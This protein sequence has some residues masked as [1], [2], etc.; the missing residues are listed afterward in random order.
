MKGPVPS[1]LDEGSG[2]VF[3]DKVAHTTVV[4]QQ[5]EE[6]FLQSD[7]FGSLFSRSNGHGC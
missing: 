5:Q 6:V 4:R 2:Y 3:S 1:V 7:I